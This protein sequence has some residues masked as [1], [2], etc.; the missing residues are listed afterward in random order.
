[1]KGLYYKDVTVSVEGS[2]YDLK[3]MIYVNDDAQIDSRIELAKGTYTPVLAFD[4]VADFMK[5]DI[6]LTVMPVIMDSTNQYY[7]KSTI[8]DYFFP[9]Q[10][11]QKLDIADMF[12][13]TFVVSDGE[14][15]YQFKSEAY[16]EDFTTSLFL[17]VQKTYNYQNNVAG[18][19]IYIPVFKSTDIVDGKV[20][21][22]NYLNEYGYWQFN[23]LSITIVLEEK[24][25]N[26]PF[27]AS[28]YKSAF[29]YYKEDDG[30][31]Q[32]L[33]GTTLKE[34][35][36]DDD[37]F[38]PGGG[39]GTGGGG[40]SFDNTSTPIE[41][42]SL[43]TISAADTGFITLYNPTLMQLNELAS[44]LWSD[45]FDIEGWRK[46]FAN[47]MDAILGV[48]IVPVSIPAGGGK[49]V[50]VGNIGTGIS[51][52]LAASQFVEVDC[53]SINVNEY[54]GAY[55][56]Y[57]PYTQAQ[58]FLPYIGTRPI[59]VD[60]IMGKTVRVV[61]H[62]DILTGACCAFV[63]CGDSVLYT[64][65]G[66]CSIPIPITSANYTTV[67]NGVISIASSIGSM[68][69]T[70]GASAPVAIPSIANSVVN[71]MKP[72]IEKSGSISGPAGIL[73]MQ[74]P[75]LI[76]TRPRQALPEL[77]NTFIGYPSLITV[78]LAELEGYTQVQSIHLEN[79]PATQEELME[80][81]SLLEGG[82]I[83]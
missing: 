10:S 1:M 82:V 21:L 14:S 56:D 71:Q 72:N 58:I 70:G 76:L 50:K 45:L 32:F 28:Y 15:E 83:F 11:G 30:V 36:Y 9:P 24:M 29:V 3:A 8:S 46:L 35:V 63:K 79:I 25:D 78:Q 2:K 26:I 13:K 43:P 12:N 7:G 57:E 38:K 64:Y 68:V 60:E 16:Y 39:S 80:I 47:P 51:L 40:G 65:N 75:Y 69:A 54:W 59:S 81:Q 61:Y 53:G 23:M 74:T 6:L 27:I 18:Y 67:V 48:S 55:L 33:K 52:T 62:V 4:A 41:I 20:N 73:N 77:Q 5:D 34:Y 19:Y 44:Y 31:I 66:Q 49:E 37:P 42:P 22:D 17:G